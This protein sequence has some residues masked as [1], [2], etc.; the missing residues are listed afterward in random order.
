MSQNLVIPNKD[1]KVV[2][3]FSGVDLTLATDL[4][5]QFGAEQYTLLLN[6]SEVTVDSATQ[7]SLDL[8]GTAEVGKI[9]A[10]ITYFDAGSTNGT[11][12]TLNQSVD[13][14]TW[15]QINSGK[16]NVLVL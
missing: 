13:T 9:Y 1:N 15:V 5:I 7:L 6:P 11:D 10:T 8:S 3:V 14:D 16:G 4:H 2:F 12:I